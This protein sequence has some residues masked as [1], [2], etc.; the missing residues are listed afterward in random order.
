VV[1]TMEQLR[2]NLAEVDERI[3]NAA[4]AAGRD[5]NEVTLVAVTKTFPI[6]VLQ[7]A[8][9][10]G[11][12]HLGE[13]RAQ[14][15]KEKA[16]VI[17]KSPRW[18]FIGNLQTN[19]V[20]NVVGIAELVHSVDRFGLAEAIDRRAGA[21]GIV[22]DVLLEVNVSLEPSKHGV[23]PGAALNLA[24]E[25]ARLESVRLAGVMT[26]APLSLDPES[27]RPHFV[28]LRELSERLRHDFP[29]ATVVSMGMT[30]DYPVAVQEGATHVR[31][32]RALFGPRGR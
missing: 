27:S 22:Q 26:M 31:I 20:R 14:E 23:E 18:H 16:S 25:I 24:H 5:P 28:E 29:D 4:D 19:K 9:D 1:V 30:D 3:R 32:G 13:N 11:L 21:L 15:L 8:L 17:G 10:A 2:T 6:E 7:I 12:V